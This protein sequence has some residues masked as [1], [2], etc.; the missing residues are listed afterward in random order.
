MM[1]FNRHISKIGLILLIIGFSFPISAQE[2]EIKTNILYDATT[3]PNLAIEIGTTQKQTVQL[4]YSLNPWDFSGDKY[5]HQWLLSPEYRWW[6]C[7]RFNGM[8]LGAHVLGG[9]FHFKGINLPFGIWP[10]M[11]H[12]HYNGWLVGGGVTFGY[13]W[14]LGEHWN[15]EA[16]I[17]LGYLRVDYKKYR[18]VDCDELQEKF[19]K[20]YVGPTKAAVSFIYLF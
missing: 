19:K 12:H 14:I 15:L 8:F 17:G 2:I 11:K 16:S 1:H 9:E 7:R 3:T 6:F 10:T 5:F 4:M 18:C 20:N 13:Q